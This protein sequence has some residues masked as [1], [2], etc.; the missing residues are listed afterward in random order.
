MIAVIVFVVTGEFFV[1]ELYW[2][3]K[4]IISVDFF[5]FWTRFGGARQILVLRSV[6]CRSAE[7][8]TA[9]CATDDGQL[10]SG[11]KNAFTDFYAK[12]IPGYFYYCATTT[13]I[14]III[15]IFL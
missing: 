11:G 6:V 3:G 5:M 4:I 13:I 8:I 7:K 12:K 1:A 9:L 2:L 10:W 14:I 15:F